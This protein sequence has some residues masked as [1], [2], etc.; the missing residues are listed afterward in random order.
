MLQ[1]DAAAT[2]AL[3]ATTPFVRPVSDEPSLFLRNKE[4]TGRASLEAECSRM[5]KALAALSVSEKWRIPQHL[6]DAL[7]SDRDDFGTDEATAVAREEVPTSSS[8][9]EAQSRRRP[10]DS[11]EEVVAVLGAAPPTTDAAP[12]TESSHAAA[13]AVNEQKEENEEDED[14]DSWLDSVIS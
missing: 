2:A 4:D 13:A 9:D 8:L 5:G 14:L 1:M 3:Y 6:L 7:R 12:Q 10:L 11:N